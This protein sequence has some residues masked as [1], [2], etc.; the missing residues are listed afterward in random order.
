MEEKKTNVILIAIIIGVV[1]L[2]GG[3]VG[4]FFIGKTMTIGKKTNNI[5]EK[6][7]NI[8]DKTL[9]KVDDAVDNQIIPA[10]DNGVVTATTEDPVLVYYNSTGSKTVRYIITNKEAIEK[11]NNILK[12]KTKTD[13][14]GEDFCTG[15]GLGNEVY[16]I[17]FGTEAN[18]VYDAN[19]KTI[20]YNNEFYDL[21]GDKTVV[22]I[23]KEYIK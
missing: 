4:G 20:V 23:L 17:S 11:V 8:M 18:S 9:D 1:C 19:G 5:I 15:V 10:N 13:C 6:G 3:L 21:S 7:L 22:D 14:S 2:A 16:I 12:N